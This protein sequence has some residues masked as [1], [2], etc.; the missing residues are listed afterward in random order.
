MPKNLLAAIVSDAEGDMNRLVVD[1]AFVAD[2]DAQG[3]EENQWVDRLERS[4]LPGRAAPFYEKYLSRNTTRC[5]DTVI[6]VEELKPIEFN[7]V[8]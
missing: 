4:G 1:Q 6:C 5:G 8:T 2:F 3:I 7:G